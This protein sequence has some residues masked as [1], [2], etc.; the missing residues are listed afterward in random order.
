MKQHRRLSYQKTFGFLTTLLM[1]MF[2]TAGTTLAADWPKN[3][4]VISATPGASVH[5]VLVGM[6]KT[7][8]KH[9]PIKKW[10][11]QPLGGPKAWL[12]MMKM[13]KC[14]FANH[15]AADMVNAFLGRGNYEK[16]GPQ[17][18]RTVGA[19]HEYM[20]AFWTIPDTGIR[21]IT[22]LKG[23]VVANK[24]RANPMFIEMTKN[25]LGSAGLTEKDFKKSLS[26]P[27][28]NE[29]IRDLI[30]GRIDSVLYPVVPNFV[31][32]IN[33]A[34]KETVFVQM[35]ANQADYVLQK[36]EGYYK[37][38][39]PAKD[40]RFRNI[41]PVSNAICYQNAMFTPSKTA[42]AVVYGVAKAI[43]ENTEEFKD[44]H[45]AA[46]FWSLKH[47]PVQPA[48]PYHDGAIRYFKEK[49]LWTKQMQDH[50]EKMLAKQKELM[51]R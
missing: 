10:I 11:V 15:N 32:Q 47:K 19:G 8:E 46:K 23:K 41:S 31:M 45:P 4:A 30:E 39:I 43:F 27:S 7:I 21:S 18:I 17:D 42:E 16:M 49:G 26:F 37:Q 48:V 25:Q 36:M 13:G 3:V 6:G 35:T 12:P 34:K 50:Q 1:I 22:D 33:E 40:P 29:A 5:M 24:T 28:I 2:F 38:D 14:Q 44:A 20:F 9:T 51:D